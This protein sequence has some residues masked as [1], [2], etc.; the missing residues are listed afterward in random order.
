[1]TSKIFATVSALALTSGIAMAGGAQAQDGRQAGA[2]VGEVV[3]TARKRE[4]RLIDVPIAIVAFTQ[5]RIEAAGLQNL[6]DVA[7]FTPGFTFSD[8][9]VTG[10]NDRS[11]QTGLVIRGMASN[12]NLATR[13]TAQL[14]V[15]GAPFPGGGLRGIE[16]IERVEVI[17]GPQSAY[18][19]RATF[20]GAV[21]VISRRPAMTWGARVFGEAARYDSYQ[22]GGSVEGPLVADRL[23]ARI[24][25][26]IDDRGGQYVNS[27]RPSEKLG[28]RR[29]ESIGLSILATPNAAFE[30]RGYL[31]YY[32]DK[33]GPPANVLLDSRDFNCDAGAGRGRPNWICGKAPKVPASRIGL[34]TT[35]DPQFRTQ[36]IENRIGAGA[37]FGDS[38]ISSAGLERRAWQSTLKLSYAFADGMTL[39][40]IS[41]YHLD[42][43]QVI[44]DSDGRDSSN[45][46]N[47][48]FGAV[49]GVRPFINWL[50]LVSAEDEEASTELRLT[51]GRIVPS[52]LD[53]RHQLRRSVVG[54]LIS[55]STAPLAPCCPWGSTTARPRPRACSVR[56]ITTSPPP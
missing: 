16:D 38:F 54:G 19:G 21:N 45:L 39:E 3:V 41:A 20:A 13:Q 53:R 40:S 17:K 56:S 35:I 33:D 9:A 14:F 29:T 50:S 8:Q 28:A 43:R 55:L 1:M 18:F 47:P 11:F 44:A 27:A 10:R 22:I 32:R 26:Q 6:D 30:A 25:G 23:A 36:F 7:R 42:R 52:A 37:I 5:A 49:P 31:S 48:F 51:S 4:E 15:D 46:R 34:N 24:S 12:S 2:Q